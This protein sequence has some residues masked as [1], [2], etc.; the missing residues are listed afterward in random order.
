MTL[1]DRAP[2]VR[3]ALL[4]MSCACCLL[5]FST[6]DAQTKDSKQARNGV[7]SVTVGN[8]AH[9]D[10]A[11]IR[12]GSDG[13]MIPLEH[14]QR[15]VVDT[16]GRILQESPMVVAGGDIGCAEPVTVKHTTSSFQPGSYI[17]Q[18]GFAEGEIF[19]AQYT[20]PVE[21]FPI[22]FRSSDFLIAQNTTVPT[23]THY[24]FFIWDGPPGGI[25]IARFNSMEDLAPVTMEAGLRGTQARVVVDQSDPDQIIIEN[26]GGTNT[27]SVGVRI[28]A[29]N[30]PPPDPC[31]PP[32]N[33]ENAFPAVDVSGVQSLNQNWIF[34]LACPLGCPSGWNRFVDYGPLCRPS[35][36]W[37]M[38]AVYECPFVPEFGA[39]C[40]PGGC[41]GPAANNDCANLGGTF[42]VDMS[43]SEITCPGACCLGGGCLE[44]SQTECEDSAGGVFAGEGSSC[45]SDACATGACCMADG[46]CA[47]L[48]EQE[49][50]AA[51]G[52]WQGTDSDCGSFNCPQPM[53]A[54]CLNDNC[55]NNQTET[56]CDSV[57][58]TWAGADTICADDP[59]GALNCPSATIVTSSPSP[60]TVD[61]R[62]P[63]A[64]QSM[65]PAFGIGS[66]IEPIHVTLGVDGAEDCFALCESPPGD[67]D[68]DTVFDVGG[69]VY[70]ITLLDPLAPNAVTMIRYL[71]D[72][73][74]VSFIAHPSN[75]TGS[76]NAELADLQ[77]LI[78]MLEE[79]AQPAHGLYSQDVD[80]SGEFNPADL[81]RQM[82][83][84]NGA[85]LYDAQRDSP[86]PLN[87][88]CP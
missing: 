31:L 37:V 16:R 43:C 71:G 36:D 83:L 18:Q 46:S 9:T 34:A 81:L 32:Q 63:Y 80:H 54:C 28:D 15:M 30:E 19:A 1:Y 56:N 23:T 7:R 39:C 13:L 53:G 20:V 68:I 24:T 35:G 52:N 6:A 17:L 49:C 64:P 8:G 75:A 76:G 84:L 60:D 27:F 45:D 47:D 70:E 48:L 5:S 66:V 25:E 12:F 88:D 73:S 79:S 85:A 61:A 86:M 50:D 62:A 65:Q 67:N 14:I 29:H 78:A 69:G 57:N 4:A 55:F 41:L 51:G 2:R 3:P 40:A 26:V 42:F 72:D 33:D 22:T 77:N 10:E 87:N 38:T 59:C 74:T 58:G 82:D 21:H 11:L 44:L